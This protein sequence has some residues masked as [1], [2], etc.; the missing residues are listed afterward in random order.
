MSDHAKA[1]NSTP[2][3]RTLPDALSGMSIAM[4]VSHGADRTLEARPLTIAGVA[5]NQLAF[6]IDRNA[7]WV[8]ELKADP[9]VNVSVTDDGHA[10][11]VTLSGRARLDDS[12]DTA[13]N[14]WSTA[15]KAFF[16]GPDD[17]S[18]VALIVD[19]QRGEY[20]NGTE[21]KMRRALAMAGRIAG[22]DADLGEKGWVVT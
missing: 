9:A 5:R 18:L 17:P 6:L 15:A 4:L 10:N 3:T 13:A 22:L 12:R 20:W 19:V 7:D 14:L 2:N 21:G 16:S 11:Y 1:S 8:G